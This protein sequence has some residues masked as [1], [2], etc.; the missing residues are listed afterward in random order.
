MILPAVPDEIKLSSSGRT[1]CCR[2]NGRETSRPASKIHRAEHGFQR[3]HQ[4]RGLVAA[5]AFFFAAAQAQVLA[6][7]ELLGDMDQMV[8][9]DQVRP[10]L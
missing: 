8:L 3:V 9:A 6:Q 2:I 10:Q 7:I 4:E 1:M 5:P